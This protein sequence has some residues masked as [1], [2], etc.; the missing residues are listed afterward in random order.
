MSY[1]DKSHDE[2]GGPVRIAPSGTSA[3]SFVKWKQSDNMGDSSTAQL[4]GKKSGESYDDDNAND[5]TE[6]SISASST[7]TTTT[8][9]STS[10]TSTS[11]SSTT[12]YLERPTTIIASSASTASTS[13]STYTSSTL[14]TI[15]S[16]ICF[17]MLLIP[18][19]C[20]TYAMTSY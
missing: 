14:P 15:V 18:R 4:H 10:T 5:F 9:S 17:F 3:D 7:T 20:F 19:I 11:T 2:T 8:T 12:Y 1:H 16:L 6:F 13:T